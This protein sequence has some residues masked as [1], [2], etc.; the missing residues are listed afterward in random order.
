MESTWDIANWITFGLALGMA[1]E[2]QWP[3]PA[4]EGFHPLLWL[5]IAALNAFAAVT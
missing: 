3:V 5:A 1:L 4:G 2:R